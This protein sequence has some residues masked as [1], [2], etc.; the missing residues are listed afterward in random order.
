M[1]HRLTFL[2]KENTMSYAKSTGSL[3]LIGAYVVDGD[4]VKAKSQEISTITHFVDTVDDVPKVTI[5]VRKHHTLTTANGSSQ[6]VTIGSPTNK[7]T[8]YAYRQN[9]YY[10]EAR[11]K[12]MVGTITYIKETGEYRAA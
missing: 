1:G 7:G 12:K 6:P 8:V 10:M 4:L 11:L 2:Y 9:G 5:D 3:S